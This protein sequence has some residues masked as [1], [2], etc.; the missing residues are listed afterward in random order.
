MFKIKEGILFQK[1]FRI[2]ASVS[3]A[4][5]AMGA[6]SHDIDPDETIAV[7]AI[8]G[9]PY[10]LNLPGAVIVEEILNKKKEDEILEILMSLFLGV[11]KQD[12]INA[13]EEYT[14]ILK[15]LAIIE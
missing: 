2:D 13:F 11:E 9:I 3:I 6:T 12:A 10:E 8:N 7:V 4:D 1:D 5:Y 14:N 15:D